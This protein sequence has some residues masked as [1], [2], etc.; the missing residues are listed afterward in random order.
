MPTR[1]LAPVFRGSIAT[2]LSISWLSRYRFMIR[3]P[4]L[5]HPPER[6]SWLNDA[7]GNRGESKAGLLH[8][9]HGACMFQLRQPE[10]LP[11]SRRRD[12]H[13]RSYNEPPW[14]FHR[15]LQ[16]NCTDLPESRQP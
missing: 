15:M 16:R 11:V 6:K 8:S 7:R 14:T 4:N 9:S 10:G 3:D 12:L 1:Y 13:R 5:D 2:A